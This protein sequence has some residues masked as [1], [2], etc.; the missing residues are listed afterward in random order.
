MYAKTPWVRDEDGDILSADREVV[1]LI[2][3]EDE[4]TFENT[5]KLLLA[6]PELLAALKA[7]DAEMTLFFTSPNGLMS[8][9]L[10]KIWLQARA[11]I[12]KAEGKE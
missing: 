5:A 9:Q 2:Q 7:Y 10:R 1:A 4:E 6:A 11:A 3:I 8:D 12:A